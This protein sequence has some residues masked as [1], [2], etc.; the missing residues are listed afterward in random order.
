MKATRSY[1]RS[2]ICGASLG[3]RLTVRLIAL[4]STIRICEA[5]EAGRVGRV[6]VSP[7][8]S[9]SGTGLLAGGSTKGILVSLV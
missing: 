5:L 9:V 3:L 4:S 6:T 2:V 7:A 8:G 1:T